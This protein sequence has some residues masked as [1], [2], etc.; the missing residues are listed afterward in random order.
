MSRS[1]DIKQSDYFF[2]HA[3]FHQLKVNHLRAMESV[4]DLTI[5]NANEWV[6]VGYLVRLIHER[7]HKHFMSGKSLNLDV[8]DAAVDKLLDDVD[9][10]NAQPGS[11][12]ISKVEMITRDAPQLAVG[13]AQEQDF[14]TIQRM[15]ATYVQTSTVSLEEIPPDVE[16]LK[17][18]WKKTLEQGLPFLVAKSDGN[19]VGYAYAFLYR[20]RSG[21]RFTVEESIY[22]ADGFKGA[23]IGQS[24]LSELISQCTGKGYKQMLAV[25]AGVDNNASIAFHEKLGFVQSGVLKN[26]GFKFG[27]WVD[28]LLMQKELNA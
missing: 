15:Y 4:T 21:Y 2:G 26:V 27:K 22:V 12:I 24:L 6:N 14:L 13:N 19:V 7:L 9:T 11:Q 20:S 25:I 10:S 3:L 1:L 5:E 16:E 17:N 8:I 28:T 23:G 18:R